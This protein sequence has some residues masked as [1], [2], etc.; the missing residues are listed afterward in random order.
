MYPILNLKAGKEANV[1]FR[2]PWV[3]SGALES[4]PKDLPHGSLVHVADRQHKI[5]GTGTYS[6]HS[7]IAV[8]VFDFRETNIGQ[9]WFV[10]KMKEADERRKI[11]GYGPGT[12]TTG[13]RVVFGESDG[14][15]GLVVDRYE[16]VLVFQLATAGLDAMRDEVV[17]ALL[18]AF[19]P[20]AIVERSDLPSRKEE[21]LEAVVAVRHGEVSEPV[22]FLENGLSFVAD[23]LNGQKT[24]FFLDQKMLR[25]RIRE[26]AKDRKV[27][28]MFSYTGA[29]SMYALDGGAK[30]VHDVDGSEDALSLA[31]RHADMHKAGDRYS[32][33]KADAFQWLAETRPADYG[34]VIVDPPALM[35]SG[36]DKEEGM[37]AYH[38][39]NR[40]AMKLVE[41]GGLFIT[42]SC[43]HFFT[44]DDLAFTLRRASVQAGIT[45]R[46]LDVVRQ[47]PD[48]PMSVYF[49]E[50]AYLK[51]FICQVL[52]P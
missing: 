27:L 18:E 48:H 50:A 35:K 4:M 37:K 49:P 28:N 10:W 43:S 8:R 21:K 36:R 11:L 40:A 34:M 3:F 16:N 19:A 47:A 5:I 1:G 52:R 46:V 39:A 17:A 25:G 42:S 51:T 41:T 12:Q 32:S 38:F 26:L 7:S 6:A 31:K 14:I 23:V 20:K 22:S 44:E 13:Y 30:S 33:E 9:A 24:G 15:P 45:L 29:A 2:H